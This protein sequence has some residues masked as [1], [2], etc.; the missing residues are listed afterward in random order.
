MHADHYE[1]GSITIDGTRYDHDLVIESG[2]IRKRKKKP[3]KPLKAKYG[4]T[5]LSAEEEIP[6]TNRRLII[7]TGA[8]GKL[9]V[10]EEVYDVAGK[11]G[12]AVETMPTEEA[13]R[14]L[15]DPETDFILHLTC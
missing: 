3:S 7:G 13:A 6:L 10:L 11:R 8:Y 4:H 5:P 9:P 15:D 2:A 1:F 14:H 12:V